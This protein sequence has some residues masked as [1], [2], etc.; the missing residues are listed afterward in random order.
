MSRIGRQPIPVPGGVNVNIAEGN[1]V[2]VQGPRGTLVQQ[3]HPRMNLVR[4]DG[5][6]RVERPSDARQDRA[7]HGLTRTLLANMVLG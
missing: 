4:E 1:L 3:L 5:E 6:L 2:T 7:L